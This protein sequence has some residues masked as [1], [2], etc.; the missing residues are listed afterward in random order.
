MTHSPIND[1]PSLDATGND[2]LANASLANQLS[3]QALLV[4]NLRA[5]LADPHPA[6][7][8]DLLETHISY[9]LLAGAFAYKIKKSVNFGFLDFDTLEK[10]HFCCLEELRLN[11]RH[12]A[13]L[14]L[15]VVP[16][17][18]SISHPALGGAGEIIEYAVKMQR[19]PQDALLDCILAKDELTP[20]LT[21]TLADTLVAFH[22]A[23]NVAD[24]ASSFGST[25][26]IQH[27][28]LDNIETVAP[29]LPDA[30]AQHLLTDYSHWVAQQ[31]QR[32]TT[33]FEARKKL[34]FVRECHGDLH[35]GNIIFMDNRLWFFDCIEFNAALRWIDVLSELAFLA[36]DIEAAAK[37]EIARRLLNTY[38]E[39][40]GDYAGLQVWRYYFTYRAMVRTKVALLRSQQEADAPLK[41][42]HVATALRYLALAR[43]HC[44][45][46][47]RGIVITH[48]FSGSGK[49]Y[50]SQALVEV[51]GAIRIRSDIE[52]KRMHGIAALQPA[53]STVGT[54]LYAQDATAATYQ[55]LLALA[56]LITDAEHLVI[57]DAAFLKRWQRDLF[58]RLALRKNLPFAIIDFN[59]APATLAQRINA[60]RSRGLDASDADLAV[61]HHQLAH[62][63]PL[64]Q[65]ELDAVFSCNAELDNQAAYP[66]QTWAPLL[67]RLR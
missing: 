28:T 58:C 30:A 33:T 55:R 34:G 45:P 26:E 7:C 27:D 25:Q 31:H 43:Q 56:E 32:H 67:A 1:S 51:S 22:A 17:T 36:M 61:L 18:G 49:T 24:A 63:E 38:L 2:L 66:L 8:I 23:I 42:Q 60:R 5:A 29:L 12:A 21:D 4:S 15:D 59:A 3:R 35:L 6:T 37:P 11:Q 16:I 10:R 47:H 64:Q 65:D 52:R 14:Y 39:I 53:G 44:T 20:A 46:T 9:V 50:L 57:V 13:A 41:Q 19:F 62:A 48:G 54:G 40:T